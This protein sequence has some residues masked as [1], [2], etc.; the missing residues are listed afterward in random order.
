MSDMYR[1]WKLCGGNPLRTDPISF[2]GSNETQEMI[3]ASE[4]AGQRIVPVWLYVGGDGESNGV[5]TITLEGQTSGNVVWKGSIAIKYIQSP[6][7]NFG[8][9]ASEVLQDGEALDA[10]VE[11]STGND[12]YL[13]LGYYL[14]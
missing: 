13:T 12:V 1:I 8:A 10:V 7:I 14:L 3:S 4:I 11:N 9:M 2:T 6:V 5:T